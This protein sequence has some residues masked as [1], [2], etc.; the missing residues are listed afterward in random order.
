MSEQHL[1]RR[2]DRMMV[3]FL[4]KK[5]ENTPYWIFER[6]YWNEPRSVCVVDEINR[7]ENDNVEIVCGLNLRTEQWIRRLAEFHKFVVKNEGI[8]EDSLG[9]Y[10]KF[11][12]EREAKK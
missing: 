5:P 12:V 2:A 9:K 10:T 3:D 11:V 8:L 7:L 1:G 4:D 6:E